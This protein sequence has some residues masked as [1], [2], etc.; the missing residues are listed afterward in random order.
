M[1]RGLGDVY[2]RQLYVSVR[3]DN[4]ALTT[5][6]RFKSRIFAV[7]VRISGIVNCGIHLIMEDKL[8][9]ET[10]I[11]G[12]QE[13]VVSDANSAKTMGSGTLDVFATPAMTAL[14]E[15]TAWMSVADQLDEGCGTVGTLLNV[16]HD[17]P[18]PLGMTVWC[19]TELVEVDGRRLVFDVAAYD[20]K[21][22]IGG[23]RHERFIIQ[24][25][26]FQAKANKKAE[27]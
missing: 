22:K 26:K 4:A 14:M 2:K 9:L 15:K 3:Q 18:T 24:N 1:S 20:A 17:A 7:T 21:G 23:G 11:K 10:G 16:T 8:M 12:R 19:E 13:V 6:S 25:E 27:Q 5:L